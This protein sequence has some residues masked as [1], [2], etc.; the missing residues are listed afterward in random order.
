MSRE[1]FADLDA[2]PL[3]MSFLSDK[4][5]TKNPKGPESVEHL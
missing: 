5:A 3:V 4:E 1:G 2:A